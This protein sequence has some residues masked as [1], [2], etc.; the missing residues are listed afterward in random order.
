[1]HRQ[2]HVN[3]EK[4]QKRYLQVFAGISTLVQ[5]IDI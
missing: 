1:M 5:E 3:K 4:T 2:Q